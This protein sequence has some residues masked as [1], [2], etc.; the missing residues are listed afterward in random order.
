MI[1]TAA[2]VLI[3]TGE[4][5]GDEDAKARAQQALAIAEALVKAYTRGNGFDSF[6]EP[7]DDVEAVIL[8]TAARI[9]AN[10]TGARREELGGYVMTPGSFQGWTL[11]ELAILHSYRRRTA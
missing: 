3:L 6:G 11:P 8:W 7:T 5:V 10:P 1:S 2:D 4:D 9:F